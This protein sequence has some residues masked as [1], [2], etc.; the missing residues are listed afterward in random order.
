MLKCKLCNIECSLDPTSKG[1]KVAVKVNDNIYCF[2]CSD[3]LDFFDDPPAKKPKP[4]PPK[5]KLP[6]PKP[7][8]KTTYQC[9]KCK[10][11]MDKK[12]DKCGFKNPLYR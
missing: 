4:K 9:P 8:P 3:V 10:L 2:E 7:K 1:T 6:K 5:P 11:P 12:C